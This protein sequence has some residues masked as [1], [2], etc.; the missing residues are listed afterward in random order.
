MDEPLIEFL[1]LGNKFETASHVTQWDRNGTV[2]GMVSRF[3]NV[4]PSRELIVLQKIPDTPTIPQNSNPKSQ[5]WDYTPKVLV[6]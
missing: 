4:I 6:Y 2:N 5:F 3:F 1:S